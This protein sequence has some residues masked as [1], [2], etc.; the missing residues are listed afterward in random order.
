[1]TRVYVVGYHQSKFGKLG[2]VS[3]ERMFHDAIVPLLETSGAKPDAVDTTSVAALCAPLLSDQTLISGLVAMIPGFAGKPIENVENACASGGQAIVN[4][5][6]RLKAGMADVGVA[7]GIE[8]MRDAEGKADGKKTGAALGTASHPAQRPGREYVFPHL[9]AEIMKRYMDEH[10]VTE[11]ELAHVPVVHY[12]NANKN[13]L[14]QMQK[15]K[16][17]HADVTASKYL[18]PGLPLKLYEC[19]QI[20]DGYAAALLCND[21]GLKKLGIGRDKAVEIAGFAQ[22]TDPLNLAVRDDILKPS[23]AYAAVDAAYAMA[24]ISAKDVS[25]AEV[26]DCFGIMGAMSAEIIRKAEYGRGAKYYAEGRASLD[27]ECPIN[28]S[29]GLIAKGHPIGATGVAMVGWA[30]QQLMGKVPAELQV[31]NPHNAVTFNI[32]GPI[33]ASVVT[34]LRRA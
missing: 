6:A 29:G 16:V 1:M 3:L 14:A 15:V 19:S 9:F 27:G 23:G 17:T 34:V 31:K 25:F 24:G 28:T 21:E 32:G 22:R 13:P 8:K 18:I 7:C 2:D 5:I 4:T 12:A 30:Y 10:G 20:S 11:A 26:H 33:C